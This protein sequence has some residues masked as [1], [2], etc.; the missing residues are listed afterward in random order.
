[1]HEG[2]YVFFAYVEST[3]DVLSQQKFNTQN[4]WSHQTIAYLY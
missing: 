1:M 4:L 2:S 3:N